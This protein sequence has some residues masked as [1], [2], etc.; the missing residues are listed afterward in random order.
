VTIGDTSYA[1]QAPFLVSAT[2]IPSSRK[3][4]IRCRSE[5]DRFML[6]LKL[7]YP[8]KKGVRHPESHA[9]VEPN[10]VIE[11]VFAAADFQVPPGH[12]P[13]LRR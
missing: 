11:P 13:D 4:L 6:K 10:L 3:A 8:S 12:R 2:Q 9:A 5:V 1:L 7:S